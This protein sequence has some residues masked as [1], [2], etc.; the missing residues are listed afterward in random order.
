LTNLREPDAGVRYL[1]GECR[2]EAIPV[3]GA[4]LLDG[5][6][7]QLDLR[8]GPSTQQTK[9]HLRVLQRQVRKL[10]A[11]VALGALAL[12]LLVWLLG[13]PSIPVAALPPLDAGAQAPA[14]IAALP[15][16]EAPSLA[17]AAGATPA[18]AAPPAISRP[19]STAAAPAPSVAVMPRPPRLP[20]SASAA[21]P[22]LRAPVASAT[23][24]HSAVNRD[25][26]DLFADT[27]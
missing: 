1:N 23:S 4:A 14:I 25:L 18:P 26:S 20:R 19:A 17:E 9:P 15:P 12:G 10:A 22:A 13:E 11:V 6:R 3:G 5:L 8:L 27:K 16:V 21:P 2:I 24:P 7:L